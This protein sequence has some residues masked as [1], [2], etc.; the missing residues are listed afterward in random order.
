[1]SPYRLAGCLLLLLVRGDID[2]AEVAFYPDPPTKC[3]PTEITLIFEIAG[4]LQHLDTVY[5]YLNQFTRGG[6]ANGNGGKI[7]DG[8]VLLGAPSGND[9][10]QAEYYEGSVDNM[11]NDSYIILK[12]K[13]D[14]VGTPGFRHT[15]VIDS[16]NDIRPNCGSPANSSL[17]RTKGYVHLDS[18]A[19]F[20]RPVNK[21]SPVDLTCYM[22]D[23][24]LK[25]RPA[26]PKEQTQITVS[27]RSAIHLYVDDQVR[28][29]LSGWTSGKADGIPGTDDGFIAVRDD[30]KVRG[31]STWL[32]GAWEEGC[33]YERHVP[34]FLNS[35]LVLTVLQYIRA[36]T[37]VEVIIPRQQAGTSSGQGLRPQCGMPG[38]YTNQ[39]MSVVTAAGVEVVAP[40]SIDEGN[41][42]GDGCKS[43]G[44][45]AGKT[46]CDH[47]TN[48]CK[49]PHAHTA[50]D[51]SYT[52][53]S[54]EAINC[55]AGL[56]W[57]DLPW[58]PGGSGENT[59]SHYRRLPCSGAGLCTVTTGK[60]TCFVNFFGPACE[61]RVC[62]G[63]SAETGD[64]SGH[65]SCANMKQLSMLTNA[66]PLSKSNVTGL[67]AGRHVP[68]YEHHGH[69]RVDGTWDAMRLYGC[70]CE[71]SWTVGLG[72]GETQ[73]PEYFGPTCKDQHCPSGDDPMT[74]RDETNCTGVLA[75]GGRGVGE[76]GNLCHVD[77]SNRGHC[78]HL[79]GQC[80]CFQGSYGPNCHF[81]DALAVQIEI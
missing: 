19:Q 37:T 55:P 60:C 76:P 28:V 23:T 26:I 75:K 51:N 42:I 4:G 47:C 53:N 71:S 46:E 40:R 15:V 59:Q 65:G 21:S 56:A 80:K 14:V 61:R 32:R 68:Y 41:A 5:F 8:L 20:L 79:S 70:V 66:L 74:A 35:T 39:T 22:T 34:G 69:G 30:L 10:W 31:N 38:P 58:H 29:Q 50:L 72:L 44:F 16:S 81:K 77:C 3:A 2:Y 11:Y 48:S 49:C 25:F 54:C 57:A 7:S 73:E 62:P 67:K 27:F 64:C 52:S 1:M 24:R 36:G 17:M 12:A 43:L 13:Y 78:D 33:C 45:C 6:C 9:E 18:K 63:G